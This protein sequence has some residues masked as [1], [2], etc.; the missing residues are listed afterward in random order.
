MRHGSYGIF[1]SHLW[2]RLRTVL[3]AGYRR[4]RAEQARCSFDSG[5]ESFSGVDGHR[6]GRH[7]GLGTED[8]LASRGPLMQ[9]TFN[10]RMQPLHCTLHEPAPLLHGSG[11]SVT[12][13]LRTQFL[14]EDL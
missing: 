10:C 5:F 11:A 1:P 4:L 13:G 8:G 9:A 6:L 3:L 12:V 2:L 14:R 7:F